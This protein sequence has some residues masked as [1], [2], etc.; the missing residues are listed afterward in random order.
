ML[1]TGRPSPLAQ[2]RGPEGRI[3]AIRLGAMGDIVFT[4]PAV[5]S[6]KHSFPGWHLTWAVEPPWA[7]L[8]AQNPFVDCV[9]PVRR[10][11]PAGLMDTWRLLRAGRYDFAV[12][13]QGLIKSA[14]VASAARTGRIFGFHYGQARERLGARVFL[15]VLYTHSP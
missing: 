4:L 1:E 3:L 13:F 10:D 14:L 8:I 2:E 11:T 9:L 7:P 6:L 5:A 12:D 15:G